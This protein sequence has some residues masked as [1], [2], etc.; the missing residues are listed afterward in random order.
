V[1]S[2]LSLRDLFR[3]AVWGVSAG[4]ALFI[5]LYAATTEIGQARLRVALAEIH[6][7][8]RPADA[9]PI[10][11]LDAQEGRRLADIVRSLAADREQLLARVA[12][13]EQSVVGITGSILRLETAAQPAL[14]TFSTAPAEQTPT[15]SASDEDIT[16]SI[17][18]PLQQ[19]LGPNTAKTEFGLDLGSATTIAALRTAWAAALR[20]HS[21]LL[22]GLRPLVQMRERPRA[23]GMELRLVAGPLPN[24]AAAARL[25]LS[26]TATGAICAPAI[27]DGQRLQIKTFVQ[28]GVQSRNGPRKMLRGSDQPLK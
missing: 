21:T 19:P 26:V 27:F 28:I 7:L 23:T 8:L 11:P 1:R 20:R 5:A 14:P 9:K 17:P 25:C 13:L 16:S 3:L 10:R 12:M 2:T 4:C 22:A 15:R 24:P 18:V 6:E